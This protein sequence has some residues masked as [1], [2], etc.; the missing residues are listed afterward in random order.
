MSRKIGILVQCWE[1]ARR[2]GHGPRAQCAR[3]PQ[4]LP[5]FEVHKRAVRSFIFLFPKVDTASDSFVMVFLF[6]SRK[7]PERANALSRSMR[8]QK[9][10]P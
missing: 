6:E 5:Y 7:L 1:V 10:A 4:P 9:W 2:V 8:I 3:N